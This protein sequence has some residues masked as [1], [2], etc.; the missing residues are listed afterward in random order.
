MEAGAIIVAENPTG[1]L[2]V[3]GTF[4]LMPKAWSIFEDLAPMISPSRRRGDSEIIPGQRG[5]RP[6]PQQA[7]E[8]KVG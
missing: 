1:R 7:V 8:A 6:Q 3:D 5:R 2:V 4:S